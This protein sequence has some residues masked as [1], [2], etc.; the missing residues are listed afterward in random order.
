MGV[1]SAFTR[2]KTDKSL[3][4]PDPGIRLPSPEPEPAAIYPA[5]SAARVECESLVDQRE[6]GS[7][8]FAK[9]PQHVGAFREDVWIAPSVPQQRPLSKLQ[10]IAP[11]P[12]LV[13]CPT[14]NMNLVMEV[15]CQT[16]GGPILR[17]ALQCL[18][19]EVQRTQYPVLFPRAGCLKCPQIKVV[20]GEVAGRPL[21]RPMDFRIEQ[22]RLDYACNSDRHLVLQFEYILQRAVKMVSP[23]MRAGTRVNQLAG[24]ADPLR[25]LAYAPL[26]NVAHAKVTADLFHVDG[27]ALISEA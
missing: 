19:D 17:I 2:A 9:V 26:E 10:A 14:V 6:G 23:Q 3:E 7:D 25:R 12:V 27:F 1:G 22:R 15:R 21:R 20:S 24:N 16:E 13:V 5:V 11:S 8:V 18:S 4:M